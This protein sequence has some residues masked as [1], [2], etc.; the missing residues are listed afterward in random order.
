MHR[1][2]YYIFWFVL[3]SF[4]PFNIHAEVS[5]FQQGSEKN[6][7]DSS[8]TSVW[9]DFGIGLHTGSKL[10]SSP[11]H[12]ETSDWIYGGV[13][14]AATGL[15]LLIDNDIRD[16]L[17]R[18]HTNFL[19]RVGDVGYNYG[20][21]NYAI[22]FSGAIYLGGKIF[23]DEKFTTTGRMLLESLLYAGITTTVIKMALGRSRPY[24]NDGPY[25]FNGFQIKTETTSMPSGH[26][27]VA[28]AVSSVLAERF[29][30]PYASALIYTLAAS[31]V[32]QRMYSD[33]HW[34]SDCIP[35]AVI[36]YTIGK[37]VVR[38][39]NDFS[40]RI[41]VTAGY[42]PGGFAFNLSYVMN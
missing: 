41:N 9:N 16:N 13:A 32:F 39:D 35:A 29:D 31:T 21:A 18:N 3:G 23:R 22:A 26:V 34:A 28:F 12:F 5:P 20:N 40:K 24:T 36:G 2:I 38:F 11:A 17:K 37:A 8:T 27:T 33:H 19:D 15:T 42:M 4:L 30:N 25:R 1:T 10:L 14:V 6:N 7:K